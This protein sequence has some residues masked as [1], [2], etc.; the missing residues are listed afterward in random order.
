[1]RNVLSKFDILP[2]DQ[3]FEKF[4]QKHLRRSDG[5]IEVRQFIQDLLTPENPTLNPYLPKD[6]AEFAA[7]V[8]RTLILTQ[9]L[10]SF[11]LFHRHLPSDNFL[12]SSDKNLP[13]DNHPYP[14]FAT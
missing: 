9:P 3:D 5:T 2:S 7:Q 6:D 4:F 10:P 8:T 14:S 11:P 1:M 13:S 12:P